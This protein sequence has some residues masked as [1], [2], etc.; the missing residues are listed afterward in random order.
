MIA[1][2]GEYGITNDR[3]WP[4]PAVGQSRLATLARPRSWKL[5][6]LRC[7]RKSRQLADVARVV[8]DDHGRV[9]V[10]GDLLHPLDRRDRLRAVVIEGRYAVRFVVLAE[11][12][13]VAAQQEILSRLEA[14]EEA[15]VPGRV[16]GR[17]EHPHRAVAPDVLVE[18]QGL[19]LAG[20]RAHPVLE[21]RLVRALRRRDCR[22]AVPV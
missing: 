20:I 18:R 7:S 16:A 2:T 14:H 19:D 15:R 3:F 12:R 22:D 1:G 8:L 6:L 11:V 10:R 4:K 17:A 5:R 13:G 21:A 9:E